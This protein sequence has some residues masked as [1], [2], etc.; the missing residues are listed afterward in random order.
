M[1]E[2][3]QIVEGPMYIIRLGTCGT[4]DKEISIGSLV[5][6]DK[7]I[8]IQSNYDAHDQNSLPYTFSKPVEGDTTIRSQVIYSYCLLCIK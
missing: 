3:R 2:G 4:P 8:C 6:S 5:V 1:R 7:S